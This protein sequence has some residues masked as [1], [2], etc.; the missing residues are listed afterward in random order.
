MQK[1]ILSVIAGLIIAA[2]TIITLSFSGAL[3]LII[4]ESFFKIPEEVTVPSLTG[5][6][7]K[8]AVS[9]LKQF[10]LKTKVKEEFDPS[11]PNGQI[12]SQ[13]PP[14]GENV[15]SGREIKVIASLGAEMI[16]VPD[17]T[18]LSQREGQLILQQKNLPVGTIKINNESGKIEEITEQTPK[19]GSRVRRGTPI[20]IKVTK[21]AVVKYEVP[22]WEGK[23]I[24]EIME[25]SKN[26]PFSVGRI[27]WLYDNYTYKDKVLR[28]T[29]APGQ[30]CT[31]YRP[32]N[33]D[34]SAG[35]RTSDLFIKQETIT[36][37]IPEGESRMEVKA[38]IKDS[39]GANI[40]YV[41][42]HMPGDR[43]QMLITS[44]GNGEVTIY[45]DGKLL[46]KVTI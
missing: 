8:D 28:Q 12:I 5:K 25:S 34:V 46:K 44:Y 14:A 35:E 6:R 11:I 41:S 20:N 4:Y 29:P 32:I 19:A 37:L 36:F 3:G 22:V 13:N 33:I 9:F 42:D 40:L 23:T 30:Y 18:G 38:T 16:S 10:N 21:G 24:A 27:R 1:K 7:V 2:L 39:R 43:I 45:T 31:Q 17:V 26:S 15:R